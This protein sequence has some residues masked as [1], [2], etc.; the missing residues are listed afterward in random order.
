MIQCLDF[1][2]KDKHNILKDS[3]WK[4]L[5]FTEVKAWANKIAISLE[6]F[7]KPIHDG[8][9]TSLIPRNN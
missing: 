7:L 6:E 2:L 4:L 1:R 3:P 8:S 9:Q 5:N